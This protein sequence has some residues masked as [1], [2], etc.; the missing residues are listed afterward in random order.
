[1]LDIHAPSYIDDFPKLKALV[2]KVANN[3]K[4]A[5]WIVKR[6]ENRILV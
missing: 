4:I 3:P 5:A 6:P 2:D 1:M